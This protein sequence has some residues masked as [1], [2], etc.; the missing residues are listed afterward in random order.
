MS[1]SGT[2]ILLRRARGRFA[3]QILEDHLGEA[4]DHG[5][6]IIAVHAPHLGRERAATARVLERIKPRDGLVNDVVR[7][8]AAFDADQLEEGEDGRLFFVE[9]EPETAETERD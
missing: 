1:G 5:E 9:E 3:A 4:G 8:A 2:V 7:Q 6:I